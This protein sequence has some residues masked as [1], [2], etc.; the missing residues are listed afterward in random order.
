MRAL[1]RLNVEDMYHS[2]PKDRIRFK[3]KRTESLSYIHTSRP[4][5]LAHQGLALLA[6]Q[7]MV[8]ASVALPLMSLELLPTWKA[9]VPSASSLSGGHDRAPGGSGLDA[10]VEWRAIMHMK[11][12]GTNDE[13]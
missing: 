12:F 7:P 9:Y 8:I 2:C 6:A 5:P 3:D 13:P 11:G 4:H 1:S 10:I